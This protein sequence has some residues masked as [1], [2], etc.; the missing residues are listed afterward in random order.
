MKKQDL[1]L[2]P[3]LQIYKPQITSILSI[4]HRITGFS[5]NFSLLIFVIGLLC[6]TLGE[7]YYLFFKYLLN[8]IPVK[9]ILYFTILGFSFHLLNGLRHIFWDF[10][11][12]LENKSSA[13]LGY[14]ILFFSLI[15][16]TMISV[17]SGLFI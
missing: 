2:S 14:L 13:V 9:I 17:Y 8:T 11:F 7:E 6:I 15:I 10:G 1:P 16:S 4:T 5:L 12:F 3:H